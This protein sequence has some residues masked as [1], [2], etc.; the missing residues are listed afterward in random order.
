MIL[1]SAPAFLSKKAIFTFGAFAVKRRR[2]IQRKID[3][4]KPAEE[5]A[6]EMMHLIRIYAM[7]IDLLEN[8][9][10]TAY[11]KDEHRLLMR[12]R[13]GEYQERNGMPTQDYERLLE[14]F[15]GS[16]NEAAIRTSLPT[17]P[18][19]EQVNALTM[20]IVRRSL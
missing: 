3:A 14:S 11:R 12:I 20:E 4:G 7:G 15:M 1:E 13:S 10:V 17:E 8:G 16:F 6:K 9:R 19:W 5:L 18:D 2:E